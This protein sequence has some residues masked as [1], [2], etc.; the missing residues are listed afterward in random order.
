M[1]A[2]GQRLDEGFLKLIRGGTW[3]KMHSILHCC[4][5]NCC[6]ASY[7]VLKVDTLLSEMEGTRS[8]NANLRHESQLVMTNVN[9]WITE[10]KYDHTYT[11]MCFSLPCITFAYEKIKC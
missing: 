10:Q 9:R 11:V 6:M 3:E 5:L 1:L 4:H 8:D 7:C 2:S